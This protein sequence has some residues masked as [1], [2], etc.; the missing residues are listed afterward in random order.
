MLAKRVRY[1][2]ETEEGVSSMCKAMEEMRA[3]A[4]RKGM[5]NAMLSN[6]KNLMNNAQWSVEQALTALGIA[7]NE[8]NKYIQLIKK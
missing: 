7:N 1:F 6:I 4:E 8:W 2:K 3:E 5:E